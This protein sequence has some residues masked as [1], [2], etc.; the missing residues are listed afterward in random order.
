MGRLIWIVEKFAGV[1]PT[2]FST[3]ENKRKIRADMLPPVTQPRPKH[4]HTVIKD[5][6]A[7]VFLERFHFFNR[8]TKLLHI[9]CV[10]GVELCR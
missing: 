4:Q 7:V 3:R 8:E 2:G 10:G 1:Q 6:T 5:T 9:P